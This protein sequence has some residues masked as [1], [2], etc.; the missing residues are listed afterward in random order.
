MLE[1]GKSYSFYQSGTYTPKTVGA[2]IVED[3]FGPQIDYSGASV[4]LVNA[5]F[6][7]SPLVLYATKAA[8]PDSG[9]VFTIGAAVAYKGAGAFTA[10]TGGVYDLAAR[11]VDSTANKL[12]RTGVSFLAGRVYTITARG[13]ITVAT[14]TTACPATSRTCLDNTAN[15]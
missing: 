9:I 7:A 13:D 4:R 2:F 3:A 6:N 14:N 11:Y 10:L 5:I 12:S 15:R 1:D 8:P